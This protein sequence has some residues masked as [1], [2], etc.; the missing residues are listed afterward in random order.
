MYPFCPPENIRK[1]YGF[2]MFSEDIERVHREKMG[3]LISV[4]HGLDLWPTLW[5]LDAL[6]LHLNPFHVSDLFLYHM[7]T[8][9]NQMRPDELSI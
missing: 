7:K 6:L 8:S 2:L 9:E 4:Y 5:F 3:G 1:P